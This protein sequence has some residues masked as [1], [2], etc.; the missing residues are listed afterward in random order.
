MKKTARIFE[1]A[2][3]YHVCDED[4]EFLDARGRAHHTKTSALR[5]AVEME[6]THAVG[7]GCPWDGVRKIPTKYEN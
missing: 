5:S 6:F 3:G 2:D 4:E 1:D 7:S